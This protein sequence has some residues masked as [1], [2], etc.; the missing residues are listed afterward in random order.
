MI[1][2]RIRPGL[3]FD[4]KTSMSSSSRSSAIAKPRAASEVKLLKTLPTCAAGSKGGEGRKLGMT[5]LAS[6][7]D[8]VQSIL[9]ADADAVNRV[10]LA[11]LV[12][13]SGST[14]GS[15]RINGLWALAG[16]AISTVVYPRPVADG[17]FR[18]TLRRCSV[19]CLSRE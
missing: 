16:D 10:R 13:E 7:R 12:G 17:V 18:A 14:G 1:G 9:D 11:V 6:P 15:F 2:L 3:L 19:A 4:P 5:G 8:G